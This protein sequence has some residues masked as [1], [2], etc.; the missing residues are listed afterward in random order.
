MKILHLLSLLVAVAA[1]MQAEPDKIN[2]LLAAIRKGN[3]DEV[4]ELLDG[5][6][7]LVDARSGGVSA[8]RLALYYRQNAIVNVFI[9]RGAN[10]DVFDAAAGGQLV[11]LRALLRT[12]PQ[13]ANSQST[14]GA[15]PLGLAAFFGR[16]DAVE[17]L[18]DA[19]A[20][21]NTLATNPA[22]PF[23]P[24]HSAMSAGHRDVFD[25]LLARGAD[26]NLREGGG[27]TALH[28]AAG[29]GNLQYVELLLA[30]GASASA[31]DDHGKLPEDFARERKHDAVAQLLANSRK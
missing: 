12:A 25:L 16:R 29:L 30:A 14:D 11:R 8:M 9:E 31:K 1:G 18:L 26:V 6:A 7:S 28:E 17:V 23:A 10:L 15:T 5:D 13:L 27:I 24:L 20:N 4:R 21:I 2:R 3:A 22:F 19:G